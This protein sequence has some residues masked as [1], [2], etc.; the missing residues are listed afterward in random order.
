MPDLLDRLYQAFAAIRQQTSQ[1]ALLARLPRWLRPRS[2]D[3]ESAEKP[4]LV[5]IAP[6]ALPAPCRE[7]P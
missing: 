3:K 1:A 7:Q 5:R 2:A 6:R 4:P